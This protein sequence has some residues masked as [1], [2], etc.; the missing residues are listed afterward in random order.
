MLFFSRIPAVVLAQVSDYKQII[1]VRTSAEFRARN[2]KGSRN[3]PLDRIH[4]FKSKQTVYVI[5][6]TGSRSKAAVRYLR[7]QGIDAINIKGGLSR[8]L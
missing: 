1:D 2:L 6:E 3:V 5:C 7:K 8:H 4:Q